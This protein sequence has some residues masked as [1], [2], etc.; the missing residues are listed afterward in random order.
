MNKK[1]LEAFGKQAAK[2]IKTEPIDSAEV[3]ELRL[4]HCENIKRM[5]IIKAFIA[6][7]SMQLQKIVQDK[8][9][10]E[11]IYCTTY[12]TD[13]TWNLHWCKVGKITDRFKADNII[14]LR[15]MRGNNAT[16][17]TRSIGSGLFSYNINIWC[18]CW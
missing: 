18:L 10:A 3:E 1:E 15:S 16:S 2:S 6:V 17:K 9:S 13:L 4:Q 14:K 7:R 5:A 8:A 12:V 11:Q